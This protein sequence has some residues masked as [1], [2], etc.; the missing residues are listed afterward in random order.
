M[1]RPERLLPNPEDAESFVFV[2]EA[3]FEAA[4]KQR[5]I[6]IITRAGAD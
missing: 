2:P 5:L 3:V 4:K 1:G 6:A